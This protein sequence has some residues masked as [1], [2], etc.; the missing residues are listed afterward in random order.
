MRYYQCFGE[1]SVIFSSVELLDPYLIRKIDKRFK[2]SEADALVLGQEPVLSLGFIDPRDNM[3]RCPNPGAFA[4]RKSSYESLGEIDDTLR[5]ARAADY[6]YRLEKKGMTSELSLDILMPCAEETP[7]DITDIWMD[8]LLLDYKHGN[9]NVRKQVIHNL[10]ASC[11]HYDSEIGNYS[12]KKIAD[13]LL[14]FMRNI[15]KYSFT[16]GEA[17]QSLEFY[18]DFTIRGCYRME[19]RLP[20]RYPL[21]SIVIRTHKR[22]ESLRKTLESLRFQDYK[23]L[24][25]IVVEDGAS[26]SKP[27]IQSDFNDLPIIYT[28][29]SESIGRAAAANLGFDLSNGEWINLLDDDDYLYPE[30]I[31]V[32]ISEAETHGCNMVFLQ[33]LALETTKLSDAPYEYV[34][35]NKHFMNFPRIDP[36]TMSGYCVTPD[37][38]VL[39]HKSLLSNGVRM[40]EDLGS[41]EDWELW[42]RL[43]TKAKWTMVPYATCVF[44]N[45]LSIEEKERRELEYS[46]WNGKQFDSPDLW[47]A[48]SSLELSQYLLGQI[49]DV[50]ALEANGDL[51]EYTDE[52]IKKNPY[53]KQ[54]LEDGFE[55]YLNHVKQGRD[56]T[57]SAKEFNLWNI[58]FFDHIR[59]LDSKRRIEE[60]DSLKKA[61]L[62]H[63]P[64]KEIRFSGFWPWFNKEDNFFLDTLKKRYHISQVD[65]P[66]YLI[67]SIFGV[68]FYEYV[69]YDGVRIFFSGENY[70]PDFNLVD[71]AMGYNPMDYPE[72][73]R[74]IPEFFVDIRRIRNRLNNRPTYD[75][76]L[77][78]LD[79]KPE[80]CNFIY[81]DSKCCNERGDLFKTI[82]KKKKVLSAGTWMNNTAN[83]FKADMLSTKDSV[84]RR[85]RFTIAVESYPHAGFITEKLTDAFLSN[86]IPIYYGDPNV[87]EIFNPK[88]FIDVRDF[89]SLEELAEEV[90]RL[91]NSP[92]ELAKMMSEP[93]FIKESY[94]SDLENTFSKFLYDIFDCDKE[95][96]IKRPINGQPEVH[97]N[98][99]KSL[100]QR[101]A[102]NNGVAEKRWRA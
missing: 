5:T 56:D 99:I 78:M 67:S 28:S 53:T 34:I 37:N 76:A 15:A 10:L 46:K 33:S 75:D 51:D 41:N 68:G 69:L 54:Q 97:Q 66:E 47:Y 7:I 45:P 84:Q 61:A 70:A 77:K 91:D 94:L 19:V 2:E 40:R 87:K 65:N 71:Y 16:K 92:K 23:N 27:M 36:F 74:Y 6:V 82:D 30:H 11:M 20:S 101:L 50:D 59:S 35:E 100:Q 102:A 81:G 18:K 57:Y 93:V 80:F 9:S 48:A 64:D 26:E 14:A 44:V 89:G 85:C 38:G 79:H 13:N 95:S 58:S 8:G 39:F 55:D 60:V 43:M 25:I 63:Y 49:D 86:T 52:M 88:A 29:T 3:C 12:R 32:G 62:L 1:N 96:V 98:Y 17:H 90:I 24:E 21:V 73:Y 72:R 42:L 4:V 83:G 31:T 22:P